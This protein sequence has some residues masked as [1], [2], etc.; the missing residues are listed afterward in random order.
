[1]AS[2]VQS[3]MYGTIN[4]YDTTTKGFCVIQFLSEEYKLQNNTIIDGQVISAGELVV[5]A[6]YICSKQKKTLVLETTTT[7]IDY[8]NSYTH[9][10][11]ST[12]WCYHNKI[13]PSHP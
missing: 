12:S 3:V 13:C 4:I 1:M 11:S 2:S 10:T 7:A 9:N 8:H 6:Q 5:K